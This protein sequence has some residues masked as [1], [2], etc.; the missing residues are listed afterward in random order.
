MPGLMIK[1][2]IMKR[3]GAFIFYTLVGVFILYGI[4]SIQQAKRNAIAAQSYSY[5]APEANVDKS[6]AP[7]YKKISESENLEL[8]FDEGRG[9]V[10]VK[11][12]DTGY[13][14]KS[15]VEEEDYSM[16]KLN[17]QWKAYLQ[18]VF[19]IKY[20]DISKRNAPPATVYAGSD[21]DFMEFEYVA[22]G[23]EVRYG[24]TG[25]G[26]FVKLQY[27]V[28]DGKFVV[29]VPYE[30]YEERMQYLITTLE[31]M[32][33]F[34]AAG[35][36]VDGYMLYPDGSGAI[37]QY[38]NVKNRSSKVKQGLLRTYSNKNVSIQ[39][40]MDSDYYERYVASLPVFGIK[41]NNDAVLAAVT[42]GIEE[43]GVMT[44]PSGIVVD[45]NRIN[46]EIYVRNVF[47]VSMFNVSTGV[48]TTSKGAE[49]QRVD[50]EF[51]KRDREITYF[52]LSGEDANYSKMAGTYRDY[53]TEEKLLTGVI[54]EGST[55]PLALEFL[56]GATESGMLYDKYIA[57]TGFDKLVEIF[58]RLKSQGVTD[59]KVLLASWQKDGVNYPDYWPVAPQI[60]GAGGLKDVDGYLADNKGTDVF[61]ENNFTFAIKE[62]GGFSATEDIV[63]SGVNVPVS[64]GYTR[65]W[66]LL[67]PQVAY[68]RAMDFINRLKGYAN[69][70]VGYEY[71]GRIVYPDYNQ[72]NPFTRSETVEIW[73]KLLEKTR[74]Q[75]RK[76]AVEG[77]NQYTYNHA[78]Y[79]YAVPLK[80]FGLSI[81]DASVPFVQMVLSGKIPFSGMAGNLSYDLAIQKLQW[82]EY[83][84]L[85][86]FRLTYEDSV[87][88]KETD[89]NSLF[90]STYDKWE[91]RVLAVY[92]E[93]QENFASVYGKQMTLHETLS[94]GVVRVGYENGVLIY[95]NY[96]EE[97]KLINGLKLP[98][99]GYL[100]TAGEGN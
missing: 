19:T 89:Y 88:L 98:A 16:D 38:A 100:I 73:Q 74:T 77:F 15:I 4:F 3:L 86:F 20:N 27:L 54:E 94:D 64:A 70:G 29:R 1:N 31:I 44:Y 63:Y 57:M 53:L 79:L 7:S 90:T 18:S 2:F 60:G 62:T 56:M 8:Y 25:I 65:T 24:F 95:L 91:E 58:E 11:N 26:L 68:D 50:E 37:T 9:T 78:D 66:F 72:S 84:A 45:L 43:T 99:K 82:I 22:N 81:E 21:C 97:Q 75:G 33:F 92:G 46:F 76:A 51:I 32:P 48:N 85:P 55:M 71:L 69:I 6:A 34:G 12:T 52:F 17:R 28:E 80:G 40:Y 59:L 5:E 93:F 67:N 87:R 42:E 13:I 10:Q 47:D 61:L 23:V 36:E 35:N 83:G 30:G 41:N 39:E 14:W 96:S 49:I